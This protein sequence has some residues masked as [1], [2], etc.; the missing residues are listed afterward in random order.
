MLAWPS[1]LP[2]LLRLLHPS[3][4]SS[5][6]TPYFEASLTLLVRLL[7]SFWVRST[8]NPSYSPI[9]SLLEATFWICHHRNSICQNFTFPL[10]SYVSQHFLK[11][12]WQGWHCDSTIGI[13]I[14]PNALKYHFS[15]MPSPRIVLACALHEC[16]ALFQFFLHQCRSFY[17]CK[18]WIPPSHPCILSAC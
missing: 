6:V 7:I 11:F 9:I 15:S 14:G 10:I 13:S 8:N 16:V 18:W 3:W 17:L 5:Q 2:P 12:W 4:A 1:C